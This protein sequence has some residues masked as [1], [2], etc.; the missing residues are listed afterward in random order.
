MFPVPGKRITRNVMEN[1]QSRVYL[2]IRKII[3]V[4]FTVIYDTKRRKNALYKSRLR[5]AQ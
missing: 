4:K 1:E 5:T 3:L 2:V